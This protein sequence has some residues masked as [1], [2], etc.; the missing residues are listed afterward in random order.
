M[1]TVFVTLENYQATCVARATNTRYVLYLYGKQKGTLKPANTIVIF[2]KTGVALGPNKRLVTASGTLQMTIELPE[3]VY[4]QWLDMLRNEKPL[5][6]MV[7]DDN[8][9]DLGTGLEAIGAHEIGA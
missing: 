9:V 1:A 4:P 6:V 5:E 7:L 3:S 8:G 2:Q